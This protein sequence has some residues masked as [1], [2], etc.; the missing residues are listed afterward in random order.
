MPTLAQLDPNIQ[1]NIL[2]ALEDKDVQRLIVEA[3]W[4]CM[5]RGDTGISD[6]TEYMEPEDIT[7]DQVRVALWGEGDEE[8]MDD[9]EWEEDPNAV[10]N[11]FDAMEVLI[12]QVKDKVLQALQR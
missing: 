3:M 9:P 12:E 7:N 10:C 4:G 2:L 8:D 5:E 11:N 1:R 6:I